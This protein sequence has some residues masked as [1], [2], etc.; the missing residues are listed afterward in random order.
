MPIRPCVVCSLRNVATLPGVLSRVEPV[1]AA[2]LQVSQGRATTVGCGGRLAQEPLLLLLEA[3]GA[4]LLPLPSLVEE[5]LLLSLSLDLLL[6]LCDEPAPFE[7]E[8][9]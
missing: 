4:L 6:V 5:E 8:L 3:T 9:L 2:R 7:L 1:P